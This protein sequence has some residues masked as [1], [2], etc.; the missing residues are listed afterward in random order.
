[1]LIFADALALPG[2]AASEPG[3]IALRWVR[4][5]RSSEPPL[6]HRWGGDH[7]LQ[8]DF[9][10]LDLRLQEKLKKTFVQIVYEYEARYVDLQL[11]MIY[12]R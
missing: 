11:T 2:S 12:I 4:H 1:M 9:V 5:R 8:G 10:N 7:Q 3:G 6:K